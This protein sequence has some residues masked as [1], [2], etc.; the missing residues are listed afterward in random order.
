MLQTM[1][2]QKFIGIVKIECLQKRTVNVVEIQKQMRQQENPQQ[3]QNK[4]ESHLRDGFLKL[5]EM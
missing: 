2:N 1:G 5:L 4:K 3:K